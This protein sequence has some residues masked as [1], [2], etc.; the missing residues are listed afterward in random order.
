MATI[1]A[2][3]YRAEPHGVLQKAGPARKREL[4]NAGRCPPLTEGALGK[5]L[6]LAGEGR[7]GH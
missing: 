2:S 3:S 1:V 5:R 6:L 7:A 4:R